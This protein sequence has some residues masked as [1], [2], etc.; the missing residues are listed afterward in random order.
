MPPALGSR[1]LSHLTAEHLDRFYGALV[2]RRLLTLDRP[3]LS[4]AVGPGARPGEALGLGRGQRRTR[5]P[6]PRQHTSNPKPVPIDVARAMIDEAAKVNPTLATLIVLAALLLTPRT[7]SA[8]YTA[9]VLIA[10]D[11]FPQAVEL[12]D[13]SCVCVL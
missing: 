1:R 4:H 3:G 10:P 12:S 13:D 9:Q 7:V 5:R 8:Q 2:E 6:P 11:P